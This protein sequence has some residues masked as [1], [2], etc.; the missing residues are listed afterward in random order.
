[1]AE[2]KRSA[3]DI[4]DKAIESRTQYVDRAEEISSLTIPYLMPPKGYSSS[5]TLDDSLRQSDMATNINSLTSKITMTLFPT[6]ASSFRLDPDAEGMEQIVATEGGEGV[7]DTIYMALS[8]ETARIN[9]EIEAQDIRP[10]VFSFVRDLMATGPIIIEKVK[11]KGIKYHNIASIGVMLDDRFEPYEMAILEELTMLPEGITVKDEKESYELY[12]AIV[13]D[14]ETK[15]W[16]VTQSIG[17]EVVGD[18]QTYT[19]ETLPFQY[20]G[21]SIAKGDTYHRPY[22]EQML[23][24]IRSLNALT[25]VLTDG[26][27]IASKVNIFVNP[28]GGRTRMRDL[29]ESVNGAI[30]EGSAEDVSAFQLQKNFDFQVPMQRLAEI[31]Q[32]LDKAYLVNQSAARD[33]ER[34]TATEVSF[35]A[36][37]L[38]T[39]LAGIYSIMAS[40]VSKRIVTWV[41]Q[42]LGIKFDGIDVNIITGLD[43]LSKQGEAQKFDAYL[44]TLMSLGYNMAV[45]EAE[46]VRRYAEFYG[47]NTTGLIKTE[48]ELA[49]EQQAA[50]NAQ[51]E[52]MGAES[53]S[54]A[55]GESAGKAMIEGPPQQPQGE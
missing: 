5:S 38:E 22:T 54:Q 24:D 36:Q 43:S 31:K 13:K 50:M 10:Q 44:Q 11:K 45:K 39:Q 29:A 55:A 18:E 2:N 53:M 4:Y 28:R 27:V 23:G 14:E 16:I 15:K 21:W 20:L 34:T 42:D 41:M 7:R 49:Q 26:S 46:V 8:N 40:K 33:S 30:L 19:D 47:I 35:M 3:K 6:A 1:M 25:Q 32:S 51:Q 9:K 17:T 48:Q 12:T 52:Q 37:E